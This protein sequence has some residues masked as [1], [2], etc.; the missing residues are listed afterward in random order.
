MCMIREAFEKYSESV[1]PWHT[2]QTAPIPTKPIVTM[3]TGYV[4]ERNNLL[5]TLTFS[6]DLNLGDGDWKFVEGIYKNLIAPHDILLVVP[7]STW[8]KDGHVPLENRIRS[9]HKEMEVANDLSLFRDILPEH[10]YSPAFVGFIG[11]IE[12]VTDIMIS[13]LVSTI[14]DVHLRG[15]KLY[16]SMG[17]DAIAEIDPDSV[18]SPGYKLPHAHRIFVTGKGNDLNSRGTILKIFATSFD[19]EFEN[20]FVKNEK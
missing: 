14:P 2:Q 10:T 18:V 16:Y 15:K 6:T 17:L 12:E 11:G 8:N 9:M 13:E 19:T 5:R 1:G 7:R 4:A 20:Y 3:E